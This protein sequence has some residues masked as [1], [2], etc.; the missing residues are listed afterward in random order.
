[1]VP[2]PAALFSYLATHCPYKMADKG[3]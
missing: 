1:M 3:D 2:Y